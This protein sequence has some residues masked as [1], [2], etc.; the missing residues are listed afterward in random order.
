MDSPLLSPMLTILYILTRQFFAHPFVSP[1]HAYIYFTNF[2]GPYTYFGFT[3][4]YSMGRSIHICFCE[5][6]PKLTD[7]FFLVYFFRNQIV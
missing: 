5:L 4:P 7:C 2:F 1:T 3:P 6:K